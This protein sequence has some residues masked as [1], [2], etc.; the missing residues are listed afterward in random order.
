MLMPRELRANAAMAVTL[1]ALEG[2]LMGIIVKTQF[3]AVAAPSRVNLA[4]ALVAG[5]PSFAN[6]ISLW[7]SGL[8]EGHSK[9][10]WVAAL[11]A[12]SS[13][14]L[15][16]MALVPASLSGL[17]LLTAGMIAARLC[18]AGAL[19]LRAAVWRAN[20]PRHVRGR[21]TGWISIIQS[22]II[23]S[24]ALAIGA[25]M[26]YWPEAWRLAF[27]L[28]GLFGLAAA[29]HY[30]RSPIRQG[31][32][33]LREELAARA[34]R[35]GGH[36]SAALQVLAR[37]RDFRRYMLTMFLFGSGNLMVVALLV[38]VLNEQFQMPRFEQV[39]VASALPLLTL[40][41]FTPLWARR[42]DAMHIFD[43]RARQAWVYVA[44]MLLFMLA[45]LSGQHVLFWAGAIAL[46]AAMAGGNIGWN[47]GHHDFASDGQSTLYMGIHVSLTGLRGL[48]AP[49]V[50]MGLYQWLESAQPGRGRL[51]LILPFLLMFSGAL[52]FVFLA[53]QRRV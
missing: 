44:A 42:F 25:W 41:L 21:I 33:L 36:L 10:R 37:D 4:V 31:R 13:L 1:G 14:V 15:I 3:D 47:L 9:V 24:S 22:L 12:A 23:A 26:N 50:G 8:A 20:F 16:L 34:R 5:A 6:L 17:L 46:G 45:S 28:A 53:R 52:I 7:I 11:M 39:L 51:A 27:P 35:S 48:L 49:V 2:G 38:V 18:W 19:T 29:L 40:P 30:L 43:F 32:R